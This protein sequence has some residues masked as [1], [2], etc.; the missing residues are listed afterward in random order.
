MR[1]EIQAN[2]YSNLSRQHLGAASK[3]IDPNDLEGID[4]IRVIEECPHDRHSNRYEPYLRGFLYN[5]H[6]SS[7]GKNG[8]HSEIVLYRT[9]IY[10]GIPKILRFTPIATLKIGRHLAHEVGHHVLEKRGKR[11]KY[12]PIANG[13]NEE[14]ED[15]ASEYTATVIAKM[16]Q[17][18]VYRL[19]NKVNNL[20]SKVFYNCGIQDY[21]DG[22][23][24]SSAQLLFR[25]SVL[26]RGSG[27]AGQ[28][29]RHA[30]EKLRVQI[31]SPL[32]PEEQDWLNTF[33]NPYPVTTGR[34]KRSK[35]ESGRLATAKT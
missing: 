29:Y 24:K 23:Y 21:W 2:S 14:A 7:G 31:P 30:M 8:N 5:G 16:L 10:F 34:L 3:W 19:A 4:V 18:P 35:H 13:R 22:N 9:D 1:I 11:K 26:T 15:S 6:Y 25:S 12:K 33:Y 32:S 27:D 17:H 20:V 28:A